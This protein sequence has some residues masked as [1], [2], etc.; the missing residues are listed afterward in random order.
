MLGDRNTR[1]GS[2]GAY[3]LVGR[4]RFGA[5]ALTILTTDP[6]SGNPRKFLVDVDATL[7]HLLEREDSDRN[8]QITIEDVGPKVCLDGLNSVWRKWC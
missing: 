6:T 4:T 3:Y 1:R 7:E 2:M 5:C 8:Q